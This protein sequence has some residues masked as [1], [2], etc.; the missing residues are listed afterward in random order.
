[1]ATAVQS[2]IQINKA[3]MSPK[4]LVTMPE[5]VLKLYLGRI[6][7]IADRIAKRTAPDLKTYEGLGGSFEAVPAKI[8]GQEERDTIQSGVLYLPEGIYETVA[9]ILKETD[10]EGVL[11]N[12]SLQFGFDVFAVRASNPQGYSYQ[13]MPLGKPTANDPLSAVRAEMLK[14]APPVPKALPKPEA[15][16]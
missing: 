14:V 11:V 1:M 4:I 6:F 13:F 3:L 7:G 2:K 15:K 8:E 5:N 9:N 10:K 12:K 16:K